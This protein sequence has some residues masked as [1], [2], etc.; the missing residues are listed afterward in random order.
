MGLSC[1]AKQLKEPKMKTI[2][3]ILLSA[4]LVASSAAFATSASTPVLSKGSFSQQYSFTTSSTYRANPGTT[5]TLSGR[6]SQFSSLSFE[7]LN[8]SGSALT[9]FINATQQGGSLIASF[10]DGGTSPLNLS[11]STN[12]FVLVNGAAT[13]NGVQYALSATR[14]K[15]GSSFGLVPAIPEPEN[16]SMLIA[17]IGLIGVVR[18]RRKNG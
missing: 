4:L 15:R 6:S 18:R 5:I 11:A 12:Y 14:L 7:L 16:Y 8:S 10:T 9:P 13:Q 1:F 17:G 2:L 3:Y